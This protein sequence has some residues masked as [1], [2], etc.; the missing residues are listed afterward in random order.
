MF[1][2]SFRGFSSIKVIY[3]LFNAKDHPR[4][5]TGLTMKTIKASK[6]TWEFFSLTWVSS[7]PTVS[8]VNMIFI[9]THCNILFTG[10][11]Y[12]SNVKVTVEL[13]F[14]QIGKKS[15]EKKIGVYLSVRPHKCVEC[16]SFLVKH[17]QSGI[18]ISFLFL[19]TAVEKKTQVCIPS[20]N[21]VYTV[22][23]TII[24][25]NWANSICC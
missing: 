9:L 3:T 8:K 11:I 7:L 21:T 20:M 1:L 12:F 25:D 22:T 4:T 5:R 17:A 23:Y 13:S 18:Q 2:I 6:W 16:I 19:K 10:K 14:K 15:Q 24:R